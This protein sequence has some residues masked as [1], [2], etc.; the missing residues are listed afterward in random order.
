ML[1]VKVDTDGGGR[2]MS[3][4]LR[5]MLSAY[6][7]MLPVK[8]VIAHMKQQMGG[9]GANGDDDWSSLHV[10]VVKTD[11]WRMLR[12]PIDRIIALTWRLLLLPLLLARAGADPRDS[13]PRSGVRQVPTTQDLHLPLPQE[14]HERCVL[15]LTTC[16]FETSCG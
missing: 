9:G 12:E 15:L 4:A 10:Q 2:S 3:P 11:W 13:S 5:W 6:R 8:V 14:L 7:A 1:D 16:T